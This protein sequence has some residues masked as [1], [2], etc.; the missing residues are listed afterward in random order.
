MQANGAPVL[1]PEL[2]RQAKQLYLKARHLVDGPFAGD[3]L[4][5]FKGRGTEFSEVREYEPGDDVRTIDWKV[6]ARVGSPY[7][8]QYVEERELTVM[9]VADVSNST[10]FSSGPASKRQRIAE[11]CSVLSLNAIRHNNRV[12]LLLFTD[13]VEAFIAPAKGRNQ[14]HQILAT[15]FSTTSRGPGTD[16]ALA[17]R[18]VSQRIRQRT[19]CFLLSDF[20]DDG[21]QLP[22]RSLNRRHDLIPVVISDNADSQWPDIGLTMVQDLETGEQRLVDTSDPAFQAASRAQENARRASRRALF[23]KLDVGSIEINTS[24]PVIGPV[25]RYFRH[26]IPSR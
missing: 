23:R 16:I 9:L 4:S 5:I 24:E 22:L 10:G 20:L 1:T 13:R 6:T 26:R 21:Y 7:V 18:T 25:K 14:A 11:L 19:M 17:I 15:I 2:Q 3:Y 8:K 12:G